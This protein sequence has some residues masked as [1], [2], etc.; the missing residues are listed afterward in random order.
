L[1]IPGSFEIPANYITE[2]V[3]TR[4][5]LAR[6]ADEEEIGRSSI[7]DTWILDIERFKVTVQTSQPGLTITAEPK[8][9][10]LPGGF[11]TRLEETLWF[12]LAH[13]CRWLL[14]MERRG[15]QGTTSIRSRTSIDVKSKLPPPVD[16]DYIPVECVT[17]LFQHYLAYIQQYSEPRYHP[18]S[19]NVL[20]VLRASTLSIEAEAL[21]LSV[22]IESLLNRDYADC[23]KPT[24]DDCTQVELLEQLINDSTLL[25]HIKRRALG[26]VSRLKSTNAGSCLRQMVAHTDHLSTDLIAAWEKIRNATAHGRE[27]EGPYEEILRLCDKAYVLFA[28]LIFNRIGYTG[29]YKNAGVTGRPC[30]VFAPFWPPKA[31]AET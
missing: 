2:K 14:K 19:V 17:M 11:D 12:V 31:V 18:T 3:T 5:P 9:G 15:G 24:A 29:E 26:A 8:G 6:S 27:I 4:S 20:Q 7:I 1:F 10:L 16:W 23:G 21:A 13:P 28:I 30:L 22:A 25:D